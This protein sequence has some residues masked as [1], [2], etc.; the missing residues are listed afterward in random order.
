MRLELPAGQL[1]TVTVNVPEGEYRYYVEGQED[2]YTGTIIVV[3][4]EI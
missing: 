2:A 3:P 4:D 1:D